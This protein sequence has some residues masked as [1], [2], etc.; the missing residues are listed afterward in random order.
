MDDD[1]NGDYGDDIYWMM[2][3]QVGDWA[4]CRPGQ[5]SSEQI[6]FL[7]RCL[8]YSFPSFKLKLKYIKMSYPDGPLKQ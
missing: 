6:L 7:P 5:A 4:S 3:D 1:D 2:S 8:L